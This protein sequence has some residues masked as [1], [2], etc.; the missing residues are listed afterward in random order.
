MFVRS[1]PLHARQ[2]LNAD[3]AAALRQVADAVAT[4]SALPC[5]LEFTSVVA[6]AGPDAPLGRVL[7][8]WTSG[9][10]R[11][12]LEFDA[13]GLVDYW[14]EPDSGPLALGDDGDCLA[15]LL[16]WLGDRS[17]SEATAERAGAGL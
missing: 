10:R 13:D 4:A 7:L 11:L 12:R 6:E 8:A 14:C 15:T 16:S 3:Y 9:P 1:I 17:G 5:H 2:Q